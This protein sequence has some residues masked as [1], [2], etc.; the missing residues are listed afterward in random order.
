MQTIIIPDVH[1]QVGKLRN[2]DDTLIPQAEHVVM[3]GDFFDSFAPSVQHDTAA[4]I[5]DHVGDEKFTFLWGNHDCHYA[6]SHPYFRCSGYQPLTQ[7]IV[8]TV[9][10]SEDWSRLKVFTKVGDYLVSHAG[11]HP[12]TMHYV[13]NPDIAGKALDLAFAGEFHNMW[14]AG[15]ARGGTAAFGG[16]TWLDW[17]QEFVPLEV[18]QI[19]GHTKGPDVRVKQHADGAKSYCIDT[20]LEHVCWTDGKDVEIV[21]L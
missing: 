8:N 7:T 21:R 4:W 13:D 6:F 11:F 17:N 20:N 15:V 14:N 3:L 10:T 2:L 19:V 12:T 16:P 1:G 5:R 9:L 18:P